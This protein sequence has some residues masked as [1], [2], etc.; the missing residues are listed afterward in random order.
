MTRTLRRTSLAAVLVLVVSGITILAIE[1]ILNSSAVKS[2]V[3]NTL[4]EAFGIT[5]RTEGRIKVRFI[6]SFAII[7]EKV[8]I[9]KGKHSLVTID[10]VYLDLRLFDIFDGDFYLDTVRL[11]NPSVTLNRDIINGLSTASVVT[12]NDAL[13]LKS[14]IIKSCEIRNGRFQYA[15]QGETVDLR[16]ISLTSGEIT[17]VSNNKLSIVDATEFYK[18]IRLN[19]EISAGSVLLPE[20]EL[21]NIQAKLEKTDQILKL[22]LLKLDYFGESAQLKGSIKLLDEGLSLRLDGSI[23]EFDLGRFIRRT[24]KQDDVTGKLQVQGELATQGKTLAGMLQNLD[25]GLLITGH[26]LTLHGI[27]LDKTFDEFNKMKKI[28]TSDVVTLLTLGPL[29]SMFNHAY[30]QLEILKQI[31]EV[32]G[33]S[34]ITAV[35]SKWKVGGGA[36]SAEDVA[37]VTQRHR[38]AIGG[39]IDFIEEKFMNLTLASVDADGCIINSEAVNGT[40]SEP[41]V[42]ELGLFRRTIVL[43]LKRKYIPKCSLFYEG[44]LE[45]P[46]LQ[47]NAIEESE[48]RKRI[49]RDE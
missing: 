32:K 27:D 48:G 18:A 49:V 21:E 11:E 4:N 12:N 29:L 31:I 9:D 7:V 42:E 2:D 33:D 16:G 43:P 28:G 37:F 35:V 23:P 3:E 14:L 39:A 36:V 45:H 30:N 20:L 26:D 34:V 19:G 25:G 46:E 24:E 5:F 1:A 17:A 10:E 15:E 41:K 22:N 8:D 13:P 38:I 47:D 6:P 44:S 40:F